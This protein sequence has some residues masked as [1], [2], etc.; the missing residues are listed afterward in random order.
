MKYQLLSPRIERQHSD[1]LSCNK[2]PKWIFKKSNSETFYLFF[3]NQKR[4][5]LYFQ[6]SSTEWAVNILPFNLHLM[7]DPD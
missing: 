2:S 6:I 7:W 1:S 4:K 5:I 3:F